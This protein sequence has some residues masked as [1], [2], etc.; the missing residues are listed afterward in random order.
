MSL[1]EFSGPSQ[2][3]EYIETEEFKEVVSN[4]ISISMVYNDT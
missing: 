4:F 3:G 1:D 2:C